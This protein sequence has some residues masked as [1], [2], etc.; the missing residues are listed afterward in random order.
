[1]TMSIGFVVNAYY[2]DLFDDLFW[3]VDVVMYRVKVYGCDWVE[4]FD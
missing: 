4:I 1:M 3:Y 2:L